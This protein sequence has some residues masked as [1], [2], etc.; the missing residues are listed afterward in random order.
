MAHKLCMLDN[1]RKCLYKGKK[2]DIS[3]IYRWTIST[4]RNRGCDS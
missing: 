3:M 1:I 4:F 2:R